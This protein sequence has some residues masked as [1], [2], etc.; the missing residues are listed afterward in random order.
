[1]PPTEPTVEDWEELFEWD[2]MIYPREEAL[3]QDLLNEQGQGDEHEGYGRSS[4]SS[5][6]PSA[7]WAEEPEFD[8]SEEDENFP[9]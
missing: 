6:G 8:R 4:S 5:N 9:D 7:H 1:M 3:E 2:E